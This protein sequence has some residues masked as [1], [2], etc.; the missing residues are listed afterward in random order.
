MLLRLKVSLSKDVRRF[1]LDR[2][3]YGK[4]LRLGP[5]IVNFLQ[6][7]S[8]ALANSIFSV[9]SQFPSHFVECEMDDVVMVDLLTWQ[10]I[11]QIKPHLV[12]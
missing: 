9:L 10:C 8:K 11:A 4:K 5:A 2:R 7:V 1:L 6:V 12:Q 3:G